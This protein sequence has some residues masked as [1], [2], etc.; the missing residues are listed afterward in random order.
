MKKLIAAALLGVA[1]S[2]WAGYGTLSYSDISFAGW[3]VAGGRVTASLST[4]AFDGGVA[5]VS[6]TAF[7]FTGLLS[8]SS[9]TS[10]NGSASAGFALGPD[11]I[12]LFGDSGELGSFAG[13]I[14]VAFYLVPDTADRWTYTA[15]LAGI[16]GIT[17]GPDMHGQ[18]Y[19]LCGIGDDRGEGPTNCGDIGTRFYDNGS[20]VGAASDFE[21][22]DDPSIAF[23]SEHLV[24][25]PW[26]SK[27]LQFTLR[28]NGTHPVGT[29]A[30]V[31][32]PSTYAM[33]FAG[34]AVVGVV[35]RRRR[36]PNSKK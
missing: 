36:V 18:A 31:P 33:M 3:A 4:T 14:N 13:T 22:T 8:T 32:E 12:S 17:P 29:V 6:N 25:S 5:Q 27:S 7:D 9:L 21:L 35:A 26:Q 20:L 23:V 15:D 34:L 1:S 16:L 19:A 30:A 2:S 28:L 11:S 24:G 10:N